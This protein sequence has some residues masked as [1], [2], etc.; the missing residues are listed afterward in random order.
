MLQTDAEASLCFLVVVVVVVSPHRKGENSAHR[1]L[2]QPSVR[3]NKETLWDSVFSFLNGALGPEG[4]GDSFCYIPSV[5]E[6]SHIVSTD[7]TCP[8]AP[9]WRGRTSHPHAGQRVGGEGFTWSLTGWGSQAHA[10][11]EG[12]DAWLLRAAH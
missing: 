3:T 1:R 10:S 6:Y 7:Q 2:V 11:A 12:M 5:L 9:T 4:F 8:R